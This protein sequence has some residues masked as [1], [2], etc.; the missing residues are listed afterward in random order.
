VPD[1]TSNLGLDRASRANNRRHQNSLSGDPFKLFLAESLHR[2]RS[3]ISMRRQIGQTVQG[4]LLRIRADDQHA[5]VRAQCPILSFNLNP[6]SGG[7]LSKF[8]GTSP[9]EIFAT[10]EPAAFAELRG[11]GLPVSKTG[12]LSRLICEL[13]ESGLGVPRQRIYINFAD[14]PAS[15]WGWNGQ[16]F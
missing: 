6:D 10:G 13:I 14:I 7:G 16:T 11:I 3:H 9:A 12:E 5:V 2:L 4:F 1:G 8:V 15:Q